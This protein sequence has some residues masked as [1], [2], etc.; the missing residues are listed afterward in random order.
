LNNEHVIECGLVSGLSVAAIFI[1]RAGMVIRGSG[2][3][4]EYE[5]EALCVILVFLNLT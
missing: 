5:R 2:P 3:N 1:P 4:L